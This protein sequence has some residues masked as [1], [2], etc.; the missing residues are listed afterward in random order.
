MRPELVGL[1]P[2]VLE[3]APRVCIMKLTLA[4]GVDD[5]MKVTPEMLEADFK[6][7]AVGTLV[8]GQWFATH[9]NTSRV[10]EGEYPLFLVTGGVLHQV[11][12]L[13]PIEPMSVWLA[14]NHQH[15]APSYASL[16]AVK[17][18]SQNIATNLSRVLP[19]EFQVQVGQP[20]IEQA[21]IPDDKGGF[22]TKSDP[23]VIVDKVFMP[24]F[25]DRMHVGELAEWK[26][27]RV[28]WEDRR[29]LY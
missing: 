27:E 29:M 11:G 6:V 2:T 23:D 24:Y 26:F 1:I 5:L 13:S 4:E 21:I 22:Q 14:D 25:E 16:S 10:G 7:S 8:T 3:S 20:L 17:S 15:P 18:A 9:A 19:Q 12:V 28:H